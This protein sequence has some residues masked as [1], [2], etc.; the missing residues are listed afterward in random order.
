MCQFSQQQLRVF[1]EDEESALGLE[2]TACFAPALRAAHPFPAPSSL[3]REPAGLSALKEQ[4][5]EHPG[6]GRCLLPPHGCPLLLPNHSDG[7]L[8]PQ[9]IERKTQPWSPSP[10]HRSPSHRRHAPTPSPS[11]RRH[12]PQ[13]VNHSPCLCTSLLIKLHSWQR[14]YPLPRQIVIGSCSLT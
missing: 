10:S 13:R 7:P 2:G 1:E 6:E 14:I 3:L 11:H 12:V 9:F 5:E 8:F 4:E